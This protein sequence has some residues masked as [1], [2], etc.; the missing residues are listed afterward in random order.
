[1][2]VRQATVR[3]LLLVLTASC[4]QAVRLLGPS[5]LLDALTRHWPG[6]A[7]DSWVPPPV[8][9][10][11][12]VS[13]GRVV[14]DWAADGV[15][16][17]RGIPFGGPTAGQGRWRPPSPAQPWAPGSWDATRWG[18]ACAQ[19]QPRSDPDVPAEQ[20]EDCLSVNVFTP[21]LGR[22]PLSPP[23]PVLLFFH[24]C[25]PMCGRGTPPAGCAG[26]HCLG[27]HS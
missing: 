9:P 16:R 18:P 4:A 19:G 2:R 1:M 12:V 10:S 3:A 11:A 23:V 21:A 22:P 24:G 27:T 15:A 14:G 8:P 5:S 26:R 13:G 7:A 20:S 6:R 25:A 17:F